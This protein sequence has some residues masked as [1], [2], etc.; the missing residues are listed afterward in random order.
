MCFQIEWIY[1][2][3]DIESKLRDLI[4]F[5]HFK[6]HEITQTALNAENKYVIKLKK[7]GLYWFCYSRKKNDFSHFLFYSNREAKTKFIF[8]PELGI[9]ELEQKLPISWHSFNERPNYEVSSFFLSNYFYLMFGML[10]NLWILYVNRKF[11]NTKL[12]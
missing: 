8:E 4:A 10:K 2:R 9:V 7:R 1:K 11:Q 5:F 3:F 6:V 12:F